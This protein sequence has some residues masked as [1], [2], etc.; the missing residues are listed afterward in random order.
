MSPQETQALQDFL[1][2]L[3]QVRGIAKDP[4]ADALIAGAVAQQPDAAYL[5]VQRAL[6]MEQ[7][8]NTAKTQ[9]ASLQSQ[10][11]IQAA[12]TAPSRSFFDPN[13]GGNTSAT[14]A[15]PA[16]PP[17]MASMPAAMQPPL[18]Q[19]PAPV[20]SPGFFGGGVGSALGTVAATAA[21]VAGGAFL[22]QG[23]EHLMHPGSSA[24]FMNQAGMAPST[25]STTSTENNTVNNYYGADTAKDDS[26][27][28]D[29][30]VADDT[31]GDDDSS[32][33]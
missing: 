24:G 10:I 22:F 1:N 30:V 3:I 28:T 4:Q 16:A 5:L 23:I 26:T 8:L 13:A 15:R 14:A 20:A 7:A 21:G 17:M 32:I 27:S 33:I 19:N 11:Q 9:I 29:D 18:M 6:L 2:Q 12:Q 31:S 25:P